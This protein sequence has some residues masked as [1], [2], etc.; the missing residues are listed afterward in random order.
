MNLQ[1]KRKLEKF[2]SIAGLP[3][4]TVTEQMEYFIPTD[5][6]L[7]VYLSTSKLW[8]YIVKPVEEY[9]QRDIV[10]FL[11][12]SAP[13]LSTSTYHFHACAP[14]NHIMLRAQL[15][16]K[17]SPHDWHHIFVAMNQALQEAV[18]HTLCNG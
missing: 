16:D 9:R 17:Q 10:F 8:L 3:F 12:Q 13:P 5:L 2:L 14:K 15:S 7:F 4:S 1:T 11:S 18:E 6:R